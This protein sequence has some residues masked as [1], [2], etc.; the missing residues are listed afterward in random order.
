MSQA[1]DRSA[2]AG[3]ICEVS[4]IVPTYCEAEN[5]PILVP[6]ITEV[7]ERARISAEI[8][9]VDD[10]SPDQ[11]E[12]ICTELALTYPI[13][14]IVRKTER[15]LS[16]AVV[17]GMKQARGAV[18]VV[19]DA[20]LSHPPERIP[21]LVRAVQSGEADFAIGSRYVPG[22][23]TDEK[24][25]LLRWLNSKIA[26]FLARPLTTARDPMAG[27]FALSRTRFADALH[28]DPIGYKIGLELMVKCKCRRIVEI[29]IYF[30]NRVR[31]ESKLSIKEQLNYL[32]HLKRLYEYQLGIIAQ[33]VQ[34]LLVGAT[35]MFIDLSAFAL[36]LQVIPAYASR[37][38]A[39]WAAMSW[40]FWLNRR[41][42][43]SSTRQ[44]AILRQYVLFCMSCGLGAII[45]WCVFVGLHSTVS[46][47]A[48]QPLLAAIAGIIT[49]T[50]SN[51]LL[52]KYV[53]FK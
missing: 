37:A 32:R 39:I 53:A 12:Q 36:L 48:D 26:T 49:G 13:R 40:N 22:A 20:D 1:T 43:F 15:G 44:R 11:T 6:R 30:Q 2:T 25:G 8:V 50:I 21:E 7:L 27:F 29:P 28:L 41:L 17:E 10:N 34:F 52:S 16:S 4:V 24:W 35:G 33:P 9:V 23:G 3:S 45:S 51:F 46:F 14:L 19:V 38:L 42:T 31:G 18:L 47:F 5:L